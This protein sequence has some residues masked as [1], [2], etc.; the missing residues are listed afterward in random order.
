MERAAASQLRSGPPQSDSVAFGNCGQVCARADRFKV[1]HRLP[2]PPSACIR[3]HQYPPPKPHKARTGTHAAAAQPGARAAPRR[4]RSWL[5]RGGNRR[6]GSCENLCRL[7]RSRNVPRQLAGN[8]GY[9]GA[10]GLA[11]VGAG[12]EAAWVER[13]PKIPLPIAVWMAKA[14]RATHSP[15]PGA[16]S[17][18]PLSAGSCFAAQARA[19]MTASDPSPPYRS[20]SARMISAERVFPSASF[21]RTVVTGSGR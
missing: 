14:M 15:S 19:H 7:V 10:G 3:A 13:P 5:G 12:V 18:N 16:V 8:L 2:L 4:P 1:D 11:G 17:R 9:H 21:L 20:G 6:G